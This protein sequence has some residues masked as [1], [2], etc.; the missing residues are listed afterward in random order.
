MAKLRS[1]I[2]SWYWASSVAL[3]GLLV[4]WLVENPNDAGTVL[5]FFYSPFIL[6][7]LSSA[8]A[9]RQNQLESFA[10]APAGWLIASTV[11]FCAV[12]IVPAV[13][14]E[15]MACVFLYVT[16]AVAGLWYTGRL[17]L[18]EQSRQRTLP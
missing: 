15:A 4:L 18:K 17:W 13:S 5:F 9:L 10:G 12:Q 1:R 16:T 6:V 2:S 14:M 7:L 3:C 8:C 11:L